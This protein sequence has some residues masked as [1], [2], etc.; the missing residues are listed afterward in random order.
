MADAD[1]A[2]ESTILVVDDSPSNVKLLRVIL[3]AAGYRVLDADSGAEALT[4]LQRDRP[5][6]VLLD[7]RMPGMSGYEVCRQI[8]KNLQ[9]ASLPVIMVTAL[10]QAEERIAGIEAGA[11]DFISKPFNKKELLARVRASLEMTKFC[12]SG[13]VPHLPGALLI[14]DPAWKVLAMSPMAS[15]LLGIS[16]HDSL[17]FDFTQLLEQSDK[18]L[19]ASGADLVD[20]QLLL[21]TTLTAR[22]SAFTDLQGKL[23]LRLITLGAQT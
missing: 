7:V 21:R 23:M 3:A 18:N 15:A 22:Q 20:F 2:A 17:H 12:R 13:I 14:T 5:D 9:F 8:R 1:I 6:A 19:L 10:S 4:I 16:A 11:T